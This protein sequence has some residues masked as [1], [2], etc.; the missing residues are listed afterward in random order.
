MFASLF[1]TIYKGEDG[2]DFLANPKMSE[3]GF[4]RF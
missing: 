1:D 2:E 4:V 3:L